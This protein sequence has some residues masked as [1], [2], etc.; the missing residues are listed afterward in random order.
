MAEN[1][2]RAACI[3]LALGAGVLL[4]AA[5][6]HK[7]TLSVAQSAASRAS[8]L[9]RERPKPWVV[10]GWEYERY[11]Y[12]NLVRYHFGDPADTQ[13]VGLCDSHPVFMVAGGDYPVGTEKFQ[14]TIDGAIWSLPAFQDEHGRQLPIPD[15]LTQRL[16]GARQK[17]AVAIGSWRRELKPSSE[18]E[19]FVEE[20]DKM[21]QRDPEGVGKGSDL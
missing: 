3:V 9:V 18:L 20:C 12:R 19:F 4:F 10:R 13:L 17:I 15:T 11:R 21:R 2:R 5:G 1:V 16:L 8:P 6:W 7:G 14:L